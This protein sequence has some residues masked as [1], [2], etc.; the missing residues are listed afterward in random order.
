V[1]PCPARGRQLAL[2]ARLQADLP[3]PHPVMPQREDHASAE[4]DR[5]L[6]LKTKLIE[7][8]A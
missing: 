5:L 6:L 2:I 7:E 1:S 8:S 3:G 4:I